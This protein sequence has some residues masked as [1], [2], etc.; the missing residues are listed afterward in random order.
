MCTYFY[1]AY[2]AGGKGNNMNAEILGLW[3]LLLFS[4]KLSIRNLMA[5]G[6]SKVTIDWINDCTNLIMMYLHNWK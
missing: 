3:G 4:Q 2:F 5:V 1:E 6:E